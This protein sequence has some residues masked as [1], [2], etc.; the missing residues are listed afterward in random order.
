MKLSPFQL[1]TL[2]A[3]AS[4][5]LRGSA[6]MAGLPTQAG[7]PGTV[8]SLTGTGLPAQIVT[9]NPNAKIGNEYKSEKLYTAPDPTAQ[10]GISLTAS[11]PVESAFAVPQGNQFLVYKGTV[12]ANKKAITFVGLPIAKYDLMLVCTDKIYEGFCLNR[13]EDNLTQ[14]D[15]KFIHETVNQSIPFFDRK[16]LERMKGATGKAG[17]ATVVLQEMRIDNFLNQNGD[18]MKGHQ[19]RSIKL[20]FCEDVGNAGWQLL[21]SREILRTDVFPDMPHDLIPIKFTESLE[22]IRVTDSI[23][24]LGEIALP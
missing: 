18:L 23:K 1:L 3:L 7:P 11:S 14:N 16:R 5:F 10:G 17:K 21:Q 20:A 19:I 2:A 4:L 9:N 13:D 8:P 22:N 12:D 24:N 15:I 6:A